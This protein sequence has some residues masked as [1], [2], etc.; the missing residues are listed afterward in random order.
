MEVV[1]VSSG[2]VLILGSVHFQCIT[3]LLKIILYALT[4]LTSEKGDKEGTQLVAPSRV[5]SGFHGLPL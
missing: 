5:L 3:Y 1:P 4:N 2:Q